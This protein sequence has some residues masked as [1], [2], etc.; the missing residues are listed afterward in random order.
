MYEAGARI[1]EECDPFRVGM[2]YWLVPGASSS[3]EM[4]LPPATN[5]CPFRAKKAAGNH[6]GCPYNCPIVL[7]LI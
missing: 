2:F 7:A 3:V 4:S 5:C 6:K 1:Q